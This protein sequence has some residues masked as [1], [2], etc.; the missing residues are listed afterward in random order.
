M[1]KSSHSDGDDSDDEDGP[2][3]DSEEESVRKRERKLESR[4]EIVFDPEDDDDSFVLWAEKREEIYPYAKNKR[5]YRKR[6]SLTSHYGRKMEYVRSVFAFD[7]DRRLFDFKWCRFRKQVLKEAGDPR[8]VNVRVTAID[9][10]SL[11]LPAFNVDGRDM[12]MRAKTERDDD[13]PP[14]SITY[15][16]RFTRGSERR[17]TRR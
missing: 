5:K 12:K 17:A 7:G 14:H 4:E 8:F 16:V 1:E 10:K 3:Y 13:L 6:Y 11:E 15:F 2:G 9:V